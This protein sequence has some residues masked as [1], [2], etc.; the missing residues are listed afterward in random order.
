MNLS[1]K[2]I[3]YVLDTSIKDIDDVTISRAKDR[4]LDSLGAI[5]IGRD[6]PGNEAALKVYA[7]QDSVQ[8]ATILGHRRRVSAAGAAT[9]NAL[10]QRSWD[11]EACGAED[12]QRRIHPGHVSGS[13]FPTAL[14]MGERSN[15]SGQEFLR[16]L[17]IGDDIATRVTV[18]SGFNLAR[19]TDNTGISNGFG[20]AVT[21]GLLT[22]LT[23]QQLLNAFGLVLNQLSGTIENIFD[24]AMAFKLPQALSARNAINSV[25]LA[26]AGFTGPNDPLG[27]RFGFFSIFG[28]KEDATYLTEDLGTRFYADK[29]IKPWSCCRIVQGPVEAATLLRQK[30]E[31]G[32]IRHVR[33]F[34]PRTVLEGFTAIPFIHGK[35]TEVTAVFN[36][37]MCVTL[38]LEFGEV[39]PELMTNEILNSERIKTL[40]Q[41]VQ[42]LPLPDEEGTKSAGPTPIRVEL[43]M[44]SGD[45]LVETVPMALG[46]IYDHPMS[47]EQLVDKYHR[48]MAQGGVDF[49]TADEVRDLVD[50]IESLSDVSELIKPLNK[51]FHP[52]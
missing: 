17:V 1:E 3:K 19:G 31:V 47:R 9:I 8:E 49:A 50:N 21:A 13:T 25:D 10:M 2:V 14:A 26:A 5:M 37:A 35:S 22:G 27:G 51:S 38:G 23:S 12:V 29:V 7:S 20:C 32:D 11:F 16:A 45:L 30:I 42:L 28:G 24:G 15:A 39:R 43:Q 46:D 18:A 48:N 33:I 44:L 40:H 41:K 4:I 6:A 52:E 34:A 36:L